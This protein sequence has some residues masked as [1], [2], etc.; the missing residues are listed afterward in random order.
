MSRSRSLLG[1]CGVVALT[2]VGCGASA[3]RKP[4]LRPAGERRLL[5]LIAMA[6]A[7]ASQHDETALHAALSQFVVDVGTL[8]ASGQLS[9]AT[10]RSLERGAMATERQA[11]SV[12]TSTTEQQVAITTATATTQTTE[13]GPAPPGHDGGPPPGHDH[14]APGPKDHAKPDQKPPKRP[15]HGDPTQ[16]PTGPGDQG[17]DNG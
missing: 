4:T 10:A 8:R 13:D 7:D 15:K 17:G 1:A 16:Q 5:N 9:A 6:R 2:V 11:A 12:S 14:P 3:A